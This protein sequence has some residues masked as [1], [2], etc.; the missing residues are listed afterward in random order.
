[1][2]HPWGPLEPF[3]LYNALLPI[4][5]MQLYVE[6]PLD[7]T[8]SFEPTNNFR[9]DFGF[10]N[11]TELLAIEI[12][13][14]EPGGYARDLRRDRL[15]RRAKVDVVHIL[16]TEIELHGEAVIFKLLPMSVLLDWTKRPAPKYPRF[17]R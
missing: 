1:M 9:V 10:W 4:P 7:E 3:Q 15:L 6:N 2:E 11:G 5:E 14:N 17:P 13:G 8:W 12:D 16:N